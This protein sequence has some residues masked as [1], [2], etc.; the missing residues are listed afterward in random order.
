MDGPGGLGPRLQDAD[1]AGAD[2]EGGAAGH[3]DRGAAGQDDEDLVHL[4][5]GRDPGGVLPDADRQ[6]LG[7]EQLVGC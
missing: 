5:V 1:V 4:D 7:V 2:L 3:L 6:G